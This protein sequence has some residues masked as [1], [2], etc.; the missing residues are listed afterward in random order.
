MDKEFM[1]TLEENAIKRFER[2]S[3]ESDQSVKFAKTLLK[4]S[5]KATIITLDEYEKLKGSQ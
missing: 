1:K 2:S 3:S 5:I 4:A